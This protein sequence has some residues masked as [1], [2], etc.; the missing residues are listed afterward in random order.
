MGNLQGK[1]TETFARPVAPGEGI[2]G[3]LHSAG[4][5]GRRPGGCD[6]GSTNIGRGHSPSDDSAGPGEGTPGGEPGT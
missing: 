2:E 5:C 4:R 1:E 3:D 6:E